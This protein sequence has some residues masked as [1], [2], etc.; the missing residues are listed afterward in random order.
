MYAPAVIHLVYTSKRNASRKR[1][2]C[3]MFIKRRIV[4]SQK[5][6]WCWF[7]IS[8]GQW[9]S[10]LVYKRMWSLYEITHIWTAVVDESEELSSQLI[11]QFKQLER[12]GLKKSGLQRDSN[13]WP[14]RYRCDALPTQLWRHTLGAR[15]I[16]WVHIFPWGVNWC[17]ICMK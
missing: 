14:P 3:Q 16:N 13:P 4:H 6:W 2:F 5:C 11:F 8:F 17:E 7:Q 1:T 15:S 12:R 10:V 9:V